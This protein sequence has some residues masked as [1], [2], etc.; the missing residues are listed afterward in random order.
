MLFGAVGDNVYN[1]FLLLHVLAVI[2]AFGPMLVYP[3]LRGVSPQAT[4][5]VHV[6]LVL[7]AQVL[8]WVFGMGLV[9]LSDDTWELSDTWIALSLAAWLVVVV[10]GIFVIR[11]GL[12][13]GDQGRARVSAATGIT[14]LLLV[15]TIYL[16]VF[17]PGA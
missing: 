17:Q 15:F 14:H 7:P 3:T 2:V 11:P 6:R 9:G 5:A 16:M 4:A 10:L 12:V 1:V 13:A 8:L